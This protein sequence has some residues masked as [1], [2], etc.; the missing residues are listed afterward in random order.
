LTLWKAEVLL[1]TQ[2]P[3]SSFE[4]NVQG[5]KEFAFSSE[6]WSQSTTYF[7]GQLKNMERSRWN[8]IVEAAKVHLKPCTTPEL[9]LRAGSS[10]A[11]NN[12]QPKDLELNWDSD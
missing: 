7:V 12:I 9:A 3:Q 6:N 10:S 2:R 8:K 1:P 5:G 4:L 11:A